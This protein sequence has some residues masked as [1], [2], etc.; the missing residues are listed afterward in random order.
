M[1]RRLLSTLEPHAPIFDLLASLFRHRHEP[2][3][4]RFSV[5]QLTGC[6]IPVTPEPSLTPKA[7][8]DTF[9]NSLDIRPLKMCHEDPVVKCG[10][11]PG[12]KAWIIWVW[13]VGRAASTPAILAQ[14]VGTIYLII[15]RFTV[16]E[17]AWLLLDVWNCYIVISGAMAATISLIII[18][19]KSEDQWTYPGACAI[20]DTKFGVGSRFEG[21][22]LE[23]QMPCC[24]IVD[25]AFYNRAFR[26]SGGFWAQMWRMLD[27]IPHFPPVAKER[28]MAWAAAGSFT[29]YL[30]THKRGEQAL[31][32]FPSNPTSRRDGHVVAMGNTDRSDLDPPEPLENWM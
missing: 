15:R 6:R 11:S 18:I 20:H 7:L 9:E 30:F 22:G 17:E 24:Y 32:I 13:H 12:T 29:Y 3:T 2:N 19:F 1:Y 21:P 8:G 23:M 25:C 31:E 16:I 5:L 4:F 26:L 28:E 27:P 10:M 14:S